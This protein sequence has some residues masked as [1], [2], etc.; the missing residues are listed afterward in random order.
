[1]I[2]NKATMHTA[3][4]F[5]SCSAVFVYFVLKGVKPYL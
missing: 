3:A 4:S 1:M 2:V 5:F